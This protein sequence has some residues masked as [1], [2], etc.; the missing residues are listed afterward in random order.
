[1]KAIQPSPQLS[2]IA[3]I[4][5]GMFL[6]VISQILFTFLKKTT[7][8]FSTNRESMTNDLPVYNCVS[9]YMVFKTLSF[10]R[11]DF[12]FVI[13]KTSISNILK[14]KCNVLKTES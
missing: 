8:D 7:Q 3:W 4:S 10:T 14:K 13:F 9:N 1:M 5:H 2:T 12:C 6:I 11:I